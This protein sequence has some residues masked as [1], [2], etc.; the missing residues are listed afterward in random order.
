MSQNVGKNNNKVY[1]LVL[2][3]G[4]SIIISVRLLLL[5]LANDSYSTCVLL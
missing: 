3:G 1:R 5:T 2:T 4:T